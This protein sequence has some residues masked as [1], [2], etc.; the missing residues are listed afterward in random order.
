MRI[1]PPRLVCLEERE[2]QAIA[3]FALRILEDV[4]MKP[5]TEEKL[6]G[7]IDGAAAKLGIAGYS[8]SFDPC[9]RHMSASVSYAA[10]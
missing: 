1:Q 3:T 2:I 4:G 7:L 9:G 10:E 8:V 5:E 6:L